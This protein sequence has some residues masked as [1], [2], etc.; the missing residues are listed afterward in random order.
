MLVRFWGTRGSLP[1][2]LNAAQVRDKVRQALVAAVR[3]GLRDASEVDGFIERHLGFDVAGAFGGNTA[4]VELDDVSEDYVLCDL[5]TGV[6]EFG[7]DFLRRQRADKTKTF[8]IFMSHL[9]WDHI[10]GFPFFVP[11]YVPGHRVEI[12]SCHDEVEE[13]LRRQHRAPSFPVDFAQLGASIDF[14]KLQP[15]RDYDIAGMK[16]RA[17][18]QVHEGDSYGWRFESA[19]KSMVYSTDS[20]HKGAGEPSEAA[21][22]EFFKDADLVVFDAMYSLAEAVSL[23]EDWGHS[24]NILGVELALRA[25]ARRLALFHHEPNNDDTALA[26]LLRETRRFEQL[27]RTGRELQVISAYDGLEVRL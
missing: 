5:G 20:E 13:A 24:S 7:N 11:A 14:H 17:M 4:S 3:Y 6:R 18:K 25:G 9:H 1:T 16:V 10:M 8:H 23:K 2:P 27:S 26:G 12:Y 19:G 22:A 15:D 21:F